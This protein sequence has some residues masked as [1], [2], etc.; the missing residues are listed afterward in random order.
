[1]GRRRS[2]EVIFN[3]DYVS[4]SE[5]VRITGIRYSTIKY[6]TEEGMVPFE[7]EEFNLTRR[8]PRVMAVERL[9]EISTLRKRGFSIPKVKEL[10]S[11]DY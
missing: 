3:S 4:I 9:N 10:L 7:Q 1:M 2:D 6:Y 11:I 5:L 8:Y